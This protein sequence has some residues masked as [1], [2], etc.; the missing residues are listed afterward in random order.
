MPQSESTGRKIGKFLSLLSWSSLTSAGDVPPPSLISSV[1]Q[2]K[3]PPSIALQC[4]VHDL[5]GAASVQA[6][7]PRVEAEGGASDNTRLRRV[8]IAR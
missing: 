5:P 2:A 3:A 4:S 6:V 8:G 7:V 1:S